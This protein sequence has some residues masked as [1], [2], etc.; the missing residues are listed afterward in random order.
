MLPIAILLTL[1]FGLPFQKYDTAKLQPIRCIQ[2]QRE[3]KRVHIVSEAGEGIGE[4]WSLA[5]EDLWNNAHGEVFFDTAEQAVFSDSALAMEAAQS[6]L[7]RPAAQIFYSDRLQDPEELHSY[8]S[9]HPSGKTVAE[10]LGEEG[11]NNLGAN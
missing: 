2:A 11:D 9:A 6:G 4:S 1:F 8:L 5:V 7:L 3:G 10:L